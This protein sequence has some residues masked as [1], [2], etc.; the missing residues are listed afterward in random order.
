MSD[1]RNNWRESALAAGKFSFPPCD[2][3]FL[4]DIQGKQLRG[5]SIGDGVIQISWREY[6]ERFA[7]VLREVDGAK[8]LHE[9]AAV[10]RL[11]SEGRHRP[12]VIAPYLSE[13]ALEALEE[14]GVSGFDLC[15]NGLLLDPPRLMLRRTGSPRRSVPSPSDRNVYQGVSSLVPRVFLAQPGF[16]SPSAVLSE[17]HLRLSSTGPSGSSVLSQP[18]VSKAL[19]QMAVDNYIVR[20]GT[21]GPIKLVRSAALLDRVERSY[22]GPKVTSRLIGKPKDGQEIGTRLRKHAETHG[23][24]LVITGLGS[25]VYHTAMAGPTRLLVYVDRLAPFAEG[26]ILAPTVA[27]PSVELI[28]TSDVRVYFDVRDDGVTRW[29]SPL[30]TYLELTRGGPR[31]QETAAELRRALLRPLEMGQ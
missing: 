1:F 3:T 11:A 27:F 12:L 5:R 10:A 4:P 25:A 17:C 13:E 28:E 22:V 14:L 15:G 29:S 6:R 2:L 7:Y 19:K 9:A 18:T 16:P 20:D 21:R 30:Q 8:A 26:D 31:E 24:R 23:V